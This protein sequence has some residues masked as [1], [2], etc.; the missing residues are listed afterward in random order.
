MEES[1]FNEI[2]VLEVVE[3]LE[4]QFAI[5]IIGKENLKEAYFSGRFK[6]DNFSKA[7]ETVFSTMDIPYALDKNGNLTIKK[8]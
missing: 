1:D 2:H 4:R 7:V 3:E 5:Q 8:Y 6:H